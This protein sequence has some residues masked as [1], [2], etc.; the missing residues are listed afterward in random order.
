MLL[1]R[2]A[3]LLRLSM[4]GLLAAAP[5]APLV[6]QEAQSR[7]NLNQ[8]LDRT[9][10]EGMYRVRLHSAVTPVPMNAAHSWEVQVMDAEGKPLSGAVLM[11][12]GGMPESKQAL[13]A[14][15]R[16]APAYGAGNYVIE[17]VKFSTAGWWELKLV[18]EAADGVD[19]V[20]FNIVL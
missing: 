19:S 1:S 12:S 14:I 4:L 20:T 18:I 8:S 11:V 2:P 7:A 13:P 9:T 16:A 6:A 5:I 15:S 10:E 17:G 3:V